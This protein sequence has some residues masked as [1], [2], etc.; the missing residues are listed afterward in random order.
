MADGVGAAVALEEASPSDG[1][2]GEEEAEAE[3][4]QLGGA[5]RVAGEAAGERGEGPVVEG[6]EEE[7]GEAGEDGHARHGEAPGV[8]GVRLLHRQR[9]ELRQHHAQ[10]HR[11]RRH[12][13]QP[14]QDLHLLHLGHSAK[15]PWVID[16][17]LA[18]HPH[19]RLVQ[20]PQLLRVLDLAAPAHRRLGPAHLVQQFRGV[21]DVTLPVGR[22]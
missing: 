11:A 14:H 19:R 17:F 5:V 4:L 13:R 18:L 6:E 1:E 22:H 15:T 10:H 21:L 8:E 12:R 3:A 2:G 7:D 9:Q 20:P 16:F